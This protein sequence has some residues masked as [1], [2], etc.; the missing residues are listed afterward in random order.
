MSKVTPG[1]WRVD[2]A[3]PQHVEAVSSTGT[4]YTVHFGT[5]SRPAAE[6]EA[7]ARL[8]AHAKRLLEM[9]E[10]VHDAEFGFGTWPTADEIVDL[11]AAAKGGCS[12][13]A[14]IGVP[15]EATIERRV[16]A[17]GSWCDRQQAEIDAYAPRLA[18]L[19]AQIA[20]QKGQIDSL[21]RLPAAKGGA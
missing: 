4:I 11:I 13:T 14:R 8:I 5:P 7:N 3:Y 2:P 6:C 18:A 16:N 20:V 9:L 17:I 21:I 10:E 15:A 12:M 1:A 19:E